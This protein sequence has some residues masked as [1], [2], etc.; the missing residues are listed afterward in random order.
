MQEDNIIYKYIFINFIFNKI[1]IVNIKK[2]K[3]HNWNFLTY[4]K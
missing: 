2:D 4:I 1:I 3:I